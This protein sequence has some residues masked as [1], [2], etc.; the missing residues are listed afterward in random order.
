MRLLLLTL[1]VTSGSC[2]SCPGVYF[3]EKYYNIEII[4]EGLN[5]IQEFVFNRN[6]NIL[7]FTFEQYTE[8]P[9]FVLGYIKLDTR[10]TGIIDGVRNA[11]GLAIDQGLNRLYIGGSDGLFMINNNRKVKV[12]EKMPPTDHIISLFVKDGVIYYINREKKAFKFDGVVSPVYELQGVA[13]NKL[14]LDDDNNILF[15]QG[16]KLYRVKIGTRI[17]NSH[18]RYVVSDIASDTNFKPFACAK[19][20]LYVYN[21]YKYVLDKVGELR[22]IDK[23][24]FVTAEE[25]IYVVR[26][27]IVR[28]QFNPIP[29]FGD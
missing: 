25:P 12:P 19:D 2:N 16:K 24:A 7:Y 15:I 14:V 27:K 22:D 8:V 18:E 4:K 1:F 3:K 23:L 17:I 28:L 5:N 9:I 26:D 10:E 20:G 6:E 21:K 11:T 13:V 29:C